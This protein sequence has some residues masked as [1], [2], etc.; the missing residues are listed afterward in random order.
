MDYGYLVTPS[1]G[2]AE[3]NWSLSS[4][5]PQYLQ[6]SEVNAG[7]ITILLKDDPNRM[8]TISSNSNNTRIYKVEH[9]IP[10]REAYKQPKHA[11]QD[12][13]CTPAME[14]EFSHLQA[15]IDEATKRSL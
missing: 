4:G 11:Q 13:A 1:P 14:L 7:G 2:C 9:Q 12:A 8:S 5:E 15:G 10:A 6:L 3:K